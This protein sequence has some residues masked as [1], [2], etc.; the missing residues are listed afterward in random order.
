MAWTTKITGI[1]AAE[2]G[3]GM[4]PLSDVFPPRALFQVVHNPP[5]TLKKPSDWSQ[6]YNDF[7]AE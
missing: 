4:V 6:I 2:L 5:P 1:T 7:I 3:D